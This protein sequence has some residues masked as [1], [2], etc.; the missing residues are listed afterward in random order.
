MRHFDPGEAATSYFYSL[1]FDLLFN[2]HEQKLICFSGCCL[3][4]PSTLSATLFHFA[5][6]VS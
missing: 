3:A 4:P 5:F 1:H 6:L 2:I